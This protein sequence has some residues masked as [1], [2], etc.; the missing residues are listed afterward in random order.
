M[1]NVR[2]TL[3]YCL[4]PVWHAVR[5]SLYIITIIS[6]GSNYRPDIT[7]LVDWELNINYLSIYPFATQPYCTCNICCW[8]RLCHSRR[9]SRY[10]GPV[11]QLSP[12]PP[13]SWASAHGRGCQN[14]D[15]NK[16]N[17][18]NY[19]KSTHA[20]H[21]Y[22]FVNVHVHNEHGK[23]THTFVN[24]HVHKNI[25][26]RTHTSLQTHT[27]TFTN[28]HTTPMYTHKHTDNTAWHASSAHRCTAVLVKVISTFSRLP[29]GVP[30][31]E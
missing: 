20:K 17:S 8:C 11:L 26:R 7:V 6:Y 30:G 23:N 19:N 29:R 14:N 5:K 12:P 25:L 15:R 18:I 21:T 31:R 4:L 24:V 22:T 3:Q 10:T 27:Q 2:C 16:N 9:S 28:T 13:G 1:D